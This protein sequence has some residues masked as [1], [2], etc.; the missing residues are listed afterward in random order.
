[1]SVLV[2]V[3]IAVRKLHDLRN[4]VRKGSVQPMFPNHSSPPK[5]VRTGTQAD[6]ELGVG[7]DGETM[8]GCCH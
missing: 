3:S 6:Q 8:A 4:L 2:R 7:A 1:M 5:G